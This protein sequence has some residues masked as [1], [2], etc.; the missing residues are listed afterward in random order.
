VG[1][2]N[3][4]RRS[5]FANMRRYS[6]VVDDPLAPVGSIMCFV[7]APG[8]RGRGVCTTLLNSACE[9]FRSEG[10]KIAEGYPTIRSSGQVP[11]AEDNYHGPLS[12]Y[13]NNGFKVYR[14]LERFAIVRR[15]L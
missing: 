8:F 11:W 4:Q 10:L 14:E 9:L 3:A 5:D 1:W 12:V 15:Q 13:L 7:V 6:V 2:C